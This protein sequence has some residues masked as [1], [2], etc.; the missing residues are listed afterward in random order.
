MKF[1]CSGASHSENATLNQLGAVRR[2]DIGKLELFLGEIKG[3]LCRIDSAGQ[4]IGELRKTCN[5]EFTMRLDNHLVTLG[6]YRDQLWHYKRD[7]LELI[8]DCQDAPI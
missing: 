4:I 2:T 5:P 3:A 1:E 8:D 7:V 6:T